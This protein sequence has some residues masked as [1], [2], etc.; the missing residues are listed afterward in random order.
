MTHPKGRE[1]KRWLDYE[2]DVCDE[3]LRAVCWWGIFYCDKYQTAGLVKMKVR[4]LLKLKRE[5]PSYL[6]PDMIQKHIGVRP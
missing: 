3:C 1:R 5:H 6:T 2:L 4:D